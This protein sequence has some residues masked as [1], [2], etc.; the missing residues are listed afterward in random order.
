MS[1]FLTPI[2]PVMGAGE[3]VSQTTLTN[4]VPIGTEWAD[5]AGNK[6]LYVQNAHASVQL[7]QGQFACLVTNASGYSVQAS[8]STSIDYP[9]GVARNGTF[10]TGAFG[11]LMTKGFTPLVGT[12]SFVTNQAVVLGLNG[13]ADALNSSSAGIASFVTSP[14]LGKALTSIPTQT[15][16]STAGNSNAFFIDCL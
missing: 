11:W 7:S 16:C 12:A 3:S 15:T 1:T 2:S 13:N 14:I 4:T 8:C 5:N 6:Y 10:A 9:I